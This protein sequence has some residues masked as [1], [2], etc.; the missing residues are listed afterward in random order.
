VLAEALGDPPVHCHLG[1]GRLSRRP[2]H[3]DLHEIV[4]ALDS[5]KAP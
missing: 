5:R 1:V 2:E 4:A 3:L